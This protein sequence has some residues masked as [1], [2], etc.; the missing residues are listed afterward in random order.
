[1]ENSGIPKIIVANYG[2]MLNE[3]VHKIADQIVAACRDEDYCSGVDYYRTKLF[4]VYEQGK[5]RLKL[6][7]S[8]GLPL[9]VK[10]YDVE[11]LCLKNQ[12]QH[13]RMASQVSDIIQDISNLPFILQVLASYE[14]S[15]LMLGF[16]LVNE[17]DCPPEH[18]SAEVVDGLKLRSRIY[19][20]DFAFNDDAFDEDGHMHPTKEFKFL[21][22]PVTKE[23][24][25]V[26]KQS[27]IDV[28]NDSIDNCP[29]LF[30]LVI[31]SATEMTN[32]YEGDVDKLAQLEGIYFLCGNNEDGVG[33]GLFYP[34]AAA[35]I[36]HTLYDDNG[37]LIV[38]ASK[39]C[40]MLAPYYEDSAEYG[41]I[42]AEILRGFSNK[43]FKDGDEEHRWLSDTPFLYTNECGFTECPGL[44]GFGDFL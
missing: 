6:E 33:A 39:G 1:M 20:P 3:G 9:K 25:T 10:V 19:V 17:L 22:F 12:T 35:I 11:E 37:F 42:W 2:R 34:N 31:M 43:M 29:S 5:N 8:K 27:V 44:T 32:I 4:E 7:V 41:N 38:P 26:W 16:E 28:M 13:C 21:S 30:D 24:A 15:K 18:I 23:M 36:N 14:T 40:V